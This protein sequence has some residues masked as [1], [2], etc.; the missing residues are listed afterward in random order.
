MGF[1]LKC[2]FIS[3]D[4]LSSLSGRPVKKQELALDT[5]VYSQL[6]PIGQDFR[7]FRRT[8]CS[9]KYFS[10]LFVD[11]WDPRNRTQNPQLVL[12]VRSPWSMSI[13]NCAHFYIITLLYLIYEIVG[14][15]D[16]FPIK[17]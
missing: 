10:H 11:E 8:F 1:V 14:L 16:G 15:F 2:W 7:V 5:E 4:L 9:W 12:P 17:L 3:H 13:E 6:L